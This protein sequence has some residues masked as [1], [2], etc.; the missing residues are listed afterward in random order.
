M[1]SFEWDETK[2]LENQKKHGVNF[3]EAQQAFD[4][5]NRIITKDRKHSNPKETRYFCYGKINQEICTVRFVYKK[6]TIR[7]YGAG[8]WRKERKI[9]ETTNQIK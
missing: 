6:Q 9:Y 3:Y 2:N 8:Y 5:P 4:D 1:V 7:I